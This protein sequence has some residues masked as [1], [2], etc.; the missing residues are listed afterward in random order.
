MGDYRLDE[1][2]RL[3]GVSAR[4]I[5]AY[6]ERGLLDPPRR[7]GRSALYDD[8]HLAQLDTINKLLRRGFNSA[9]IAEFFTSMR[10]GADLADILGLQRGTFTPRSGSRSAETTQPVAAARPL[11][12]EAGSEEARRLVEFDL[13]QSVDGAVRLTDP[14]LAAIVARAADQMIYIRALLRI[15]ESSR[16]DIDALAAAVVAALEECLTARFG[17][18][19]LPNPDQLAEFSQIVRD[20]REL[21][22]KLVV[23][24]LDTALQRR[25]VSSDSGVLVNGEW[26]PRSG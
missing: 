21:A 7:V 24:H 5:R 12:I 14:A 23:D 15:V 18:D 17:P 2:A 22:N 19:H 4:N 1:L 20:Y 9:H 16:Q 3:S 11:D 10:D 6:R 25:M 13:A 8:S 26:L